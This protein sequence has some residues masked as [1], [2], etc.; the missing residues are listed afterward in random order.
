MSFWQDSNARLRTRH[1]WGGG[2]AV[3]TGG[4]IASTES[5]QTQNQPHSSVKLN[6]GVKA[7]RGVASPMA[8]FARSGARTT[9]QASASLAH[10]SKL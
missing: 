10:T 8:A 9:K 1:A 5:V 7:M 3:L 2:L 6:H 4:S